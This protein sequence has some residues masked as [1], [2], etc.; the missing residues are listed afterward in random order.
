MIIDKRKA[1]ICPKCGERRERDQFYFRFIINKA[2]DKVAYNQGNGCKVCRVKKQP[3]E[4]VKKKRCHRCYKY[5]E[6]K[7]YRKVKRGN[8]KVLSNYCPACE[9]QVKKKT[10]IDYK[11]KAAERFIHNNDYLYGWIGTKPRKELLKIFRINP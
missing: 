7:Q 2:G 4:T 6:V 5:V 9:P 8:A 11:A 1:A 10:N 3:K